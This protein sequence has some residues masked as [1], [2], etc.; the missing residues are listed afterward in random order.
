MRPLSQASKLWPALVA[1]TQP[2]ATSGRALCFLVR[3][4]ACLVFLSSTGRRNPAAAVTLLGF[5]TCG[6]FHTPA[7]I[8]MQE[9]MLYASRKVDSDVVF[10]F[11]PQARV[12]YLFF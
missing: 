5:V 1:G 10:F 12:V 4:D 3:R 9:D 7:A 8:G 2:L 11:L 6:H